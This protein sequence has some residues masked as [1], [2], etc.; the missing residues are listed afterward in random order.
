M[1][2]LVSLIIRDEPDETPPLVLPRRWW[3][4]NL[5]VAGEFHRIGL[6]PAIDEQSAAS[7]LAIAL[8]PERPL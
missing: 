4:L 3:S 2:R 8:G 1:T 6:V 7:M 5:V